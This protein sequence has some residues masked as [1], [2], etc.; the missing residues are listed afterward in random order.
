[1][2]R[3]DQN[4]GEM[5]HTFVSDMV[6]VCPPFSIL[7]LA[8]DERK[9]QQNELVGGNESRGDSNQFLN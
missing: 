6:C 5:L 3:E 1:M 9:L 2:G 4:K 7:P 8:V